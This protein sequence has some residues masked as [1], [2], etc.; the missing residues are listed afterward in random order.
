[1]HANVLGEVDIL[2]THHWV[3]GIGIDSIKIEKITPTK[4]FIDEEGY[5]NIKRQFGS[6]GDYSRG[7]GFA[8][9]NLTILM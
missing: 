3:E 5:V 4:V 7:M 8:L 6:D 2:A 1:M 9:I